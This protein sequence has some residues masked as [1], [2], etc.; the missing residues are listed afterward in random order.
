MKFSNVYQ[1]FSLF[2]V[3]IKKKINRDTCMKKQEGPPIGGSVRNATSLIPQRLSYIVFAI[4]CSEN[5]HALQC[6]ESHGRLDRDNNTI[7]A[8]YVMPSN[9]NQ[10]S[11]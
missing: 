2:A 8:I 6:I 11:T 3:N 4:T 9:R 5:V 7:P 10:Q 1:Y